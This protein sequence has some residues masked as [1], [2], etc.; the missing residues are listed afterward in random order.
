AN[1]AVASIT[2]TP[3]STWKAIVRRRGWPKLIKT[4]GTRRDATD[5]AR[6]TEDEMVRG[7]FIQRANAERLLLG[8]GEERRLPAACSRHSNP[9]LGW[10]VQLA[11][12][13]EMRVGEVQS[14]RRNRV[15]LTRRVYYPAIEV[16]RIINAGDEH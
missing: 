9:M 6:R 14:L 4:F 8:G 15:D 5:W 11:L 2:K 16:A 7:V 13:S 12:H 1:R 10:M 3:S